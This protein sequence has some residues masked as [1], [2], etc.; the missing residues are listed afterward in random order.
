MSGSIDG[1]AMSARVC[2][3]TDAA[4]QVRTRD[5]VA[6]SQDMRVTGLVRTGD[7][8]VREGVG[9]RISLTVGG[10]ASSFTLADTGSC[11]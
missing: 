6:F 7:V 1:A 5:D 2:V 9:P 4:L 10:T 11:S 3:P 8:W